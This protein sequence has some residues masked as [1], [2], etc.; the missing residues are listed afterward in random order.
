MRGARSGALHAKIVQIAEIARLVSIVMRSII[1]HFQ[2]APTQTV[3]PISPLLH[4]LHTLH[5]EIKI[6]FQGLILLE[7][8]FRI[9][10]LVIVPSL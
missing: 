10:I 7:L 2:H 9:R 6:L 8:L 3:R 5:L 1:V 4:I